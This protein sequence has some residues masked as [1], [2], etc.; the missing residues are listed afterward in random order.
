MDSKRAFALV[1]RE[2]REEAGLTQEELAAE[3]GFD[4]T[5]ISL[6]ERQKQ[7]PRLESLFR[8]CEILGVKPS[9][10]LARMESR[11]EHG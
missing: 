2:C 3:A 8:L 1:L 9:E 4:R 6:L 11:L 10:V 7:S 5:Y